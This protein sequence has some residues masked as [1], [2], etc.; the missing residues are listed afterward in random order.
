MVS[1]LFNK[2]PNE[3]SEMN[4]RERILA[5]F[6]RKKPDRLPWMPRLDHWYNINK[7]MG[8][9]PPE[10]RGLDLVDIY[11]DLD[12][13]WRHYVHPLKITYEDVRTAVRQKD[14]HVLTIYETPIGTLS[15][16]TRISSRPDTPHSRYSE[17]LIKDVKG[18]KIFEY[19]LENQRVEFDMEA[20]RRFEG[21]L[22]GQGMLWYYFPRIPLQRLMINLMGIER[23]L[24]SLYRYPS[25][26]KGLIEA[27]EAADDAFF[28]V[29]G[30][31][32]FEVVNFG[33]NLDSRLISPSI[34]KRY[35]LP[36]Y[37]RR[38]GELHRKGKFVHCHVDG[39]TKPFLPFFKETGWDGI[40]ALTTK[41]VGDV[42]LD[43]MKDALGDE[44]IL[45]DGISYYHFLPILSH[46]EFEG[47]TRKII[48]EF[49]NNLILG[50]SDELPPDGDIE[51]VRLI[52][53]IIDQEWT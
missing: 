28:E 26:M 48:R 13:S 6:R 32:P 20:F 36:H 40:E 52:T 41:P 35:Y 14:D 23:T 17:W 43:E 37:Q 29:I 1:Q 18:F 44:M 4:H 15:T 50:I 53:E 3:D 46:E 7:K 8:T 34:F 31:S 27:M 33:D 51:R 42:T 25:E 39:Y 9:L 45:I 10:Y 22:R 38:S 30:D 2:N 47:F 19:I 21:E 24:I 5:V 12:A 49:S 16:R 11:R